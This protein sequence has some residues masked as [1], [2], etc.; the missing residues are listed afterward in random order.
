MA[1]KGIKTI[2][3]YAIRQW[4][5]NQGFVESAFTLTMYDGKGILMD[6]NEDTLTLIYDGVEK[7]VYVKE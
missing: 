2:A 6:K 4:M 3:E 5:R 1:I 7:A